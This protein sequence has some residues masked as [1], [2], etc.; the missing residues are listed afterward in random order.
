MNIVRGVQNET[1]ELLKKSLMVILN[2]LVI[3]GAIYTYYVCVCVGL[4]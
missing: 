3:S 2:G 1:C 4:C